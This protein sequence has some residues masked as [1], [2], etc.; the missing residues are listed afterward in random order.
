[1]SHKS[2][3]RR[4]NVAGYLFALPA[5]LGFLLFVAGPMAASLFFS[6]TEYTGFTPPTFIGTEN[7]KTLFSGENIYFYNSLKVTGWYVILAVPS[8]LIL[9]LAIAMALSLNIKGRALFRTIFYLPSI[10]P[11]IASSAIF[12][13]MFN[14]EYGLLNVVLKSVGL[15]G[16]KWIYARETAVPSI[17][18]MHLWS[19]GQQ[20]VIFLAGINNIPR[21]YYEALEVDGGGWRHKFFNITLPMLT[22]TIFF[23]L[24][25]QLIQQFQVFTQGYIMTEGGPNN[26]TH[27][28]SLYLYQEAFKNFR[29]GRAS[30]LAWVLFI[31]VGILSLTLFKSSKNWVYYEGGDS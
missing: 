9:S 3:K 1:M 29:M 8:S 16:L 17:A 14:P 31:I 26:A 7:Y 2:I 12:I 10:V 19:I 28:Y 11:V 21:Q 22:P 30:A 15:P 6:L 27:F 23:N 18:F 24:V 25:M 5:I 13:W 20:M 4:D